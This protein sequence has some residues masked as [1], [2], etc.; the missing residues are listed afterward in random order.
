MLE[1]TVVATQRPANRL[2]PVERA[3]TAQKPVDPAPVEAELVA[4]EFRSVLP[5]HREVAAHVEGHIGASSFAE[6]TSRLG[7]A[8]DEID[9][10][11]EERIHQEFDHQVG[12]L[13]HAE[14]TIADAAFQRHDTDAWEDTKTET[15]VAGPAPWSD[16]F[17]DPESIRR[18][19]VLTEILRPPTERW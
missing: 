11:I 8:V 5:S 3:P 14:S 7:E 4:D 13:A 17:K 15:P 10:N 18:A 1:P 6:R 19:I 2:T 12:S 9:E 16:V